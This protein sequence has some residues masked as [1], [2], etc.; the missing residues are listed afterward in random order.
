[1]KKVVFKIY[2]SFFTLVAQTFTRDFDLLSN[3]V[4]SNFIA[5]STLNY[6][7]ALGV[8]FFVYLK[9]RYNIWKCGC[10]CKTPKCKIYDFKKRMLHKLSDGL[11]E[12]EGDEEFESVF[13]GVLLTD[14]QRERLQEKRAQRIKAAKKKSDPGLSKTTSIHPTGGL[15]RRANL[16]S[17][18]PP[19]NLG[20]RSRSR[21]SGIKR[22]ENNLK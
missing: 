18:L 20:G 19:L 17:E 2:A 10:L 15:G 14:A 8:P 12:C 16:D 13:D 22:H 7:M 3:Q 4:S 5:T 11:D 21:N 1:M 6:G 9:N